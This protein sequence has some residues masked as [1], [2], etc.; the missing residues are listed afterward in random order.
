VGQIP[1]PARS[2]IHRFLPEGA[3]SQ[4]AEGSL[5]ET[6]YFLVL[7]HDLGYADTAPLITALEEVSRLLSAYAPPFCL[8][9][10]PSLYHT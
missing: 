2:H 3:V 9:S 4:M 6:R 10:S 1:D 5:E 7:A 8:P